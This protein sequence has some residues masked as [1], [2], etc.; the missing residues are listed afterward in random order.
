MSTLA[1]CLIGGAAGLASFTITYILLSTLLINRDTRRRKRHKKEPEVLGK[2]VEKHVSEDGLTFTAKLTTHGEDAVDALRFATGYKDTLEDGIG[3]W[4]DNKRYDMTPMQIMTPN[5][6]REMHGCKYVW[7]GPLPEPRIEEY[8][9]IEHW[10]GKT[11]TKL[12]RCEYCG[13]FSDLVKGTC[14]HCGAPL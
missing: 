8:G 2:V 7:N 4:A 1:K 3:F 5:E 10:D 14:D 9:T 13:C 12:K 6:H 11:I